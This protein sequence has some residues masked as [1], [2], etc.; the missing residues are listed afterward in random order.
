MILVTGGTGFVGSAIV[1]RLAADGHRPRVLV[2]RPATTAARRLQEETGC[3][4]HAGSV[5]DPASLPAA[6]EGVRAVIHLVG[7]IFESGA[8]TFDRVHA[9]GTRHVADACRTAGISRLVHMSASGT[10]AHAIAPYHRSKWDGECAVRESGLDWTIFRPAII[11]GPGN[12]FTSILV[13]QMTPPWRW[14]TAGVMPMIGDGTALMQPVHVREVAD[15]FVRSL[16]T[17]A[18]IR[19]TYELGGRA[20]PYRDLLQT[21]ARQEGVRIHPLPLPRELA[22]AGAALIEV[23]SP[24]KIPTPGHVAM[25]EEDQNADTGPAQ[26]DLAFAPLP[27]AEGL[28]AG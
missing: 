11:Y 22:Y 12:G 24:W 28:R 23:V 8:Q 25:L 1:R 6:L 4:L 18:A 27:F 5:T 19:K 9:A 15:A 14:L 20:I 17:P 7:I 10:R 2:R 26:H 3:T 16:D 21:L 13:R